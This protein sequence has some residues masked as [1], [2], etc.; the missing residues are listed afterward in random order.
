[1]GITILERE[2]RVPSKGRASANSQRREYHAHAREK[3]E[4]VREGSSRRLD[5][6]G[7]SR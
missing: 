6:K 5:W 3:S 1:M 2:K 4:G 7:R